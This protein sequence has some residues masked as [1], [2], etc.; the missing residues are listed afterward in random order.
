M[1]NAANA[2]SSGSGGLGLMMQPT[3]RSRKMATKAKAPAVDETVVLPPILKKTIQVRVVGDTPLIV[4]RWS[5]KA[6]EEILA[7][8]MKK[9]KP[10]KA[11]KDPEGDY[12]ESLYQLPDGSYG[13]PA[14]AF[15]NA[16]VTAC[17]SLD[18]KK[19]M[20]KTK[21][22]QIMHIVADD[23]DMVRINGTPRM[24]EDMVRLNGTTADIRYRGEFP[25]WSADL[26]IVFNANVVSEAQVLNIL[27]L[28]GFGVGVGE[29]RPERNGQFG[30]FH[31]E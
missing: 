18:D 25:E 23:A 31:V 27:N 15:K 16:A 8:Q 13:F 17:T 20:P 10:A 30:R 5:K 11:A 24:R 7:K 6:R 2:A 12:R 4:H 26:T 19:N 14:T 28:A 1:R 3:E 21:A 22:R 9:A 29:W